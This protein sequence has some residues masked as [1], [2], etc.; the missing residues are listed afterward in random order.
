MGGASSYSYR[1]GEGGKPGV[2]TPIVFSGTV[3]LFITGLCTDRPVW[4]PVRLRAQRQERHA[5]LLTG[6][7][8]KRITLFEERLRLLLVMPFSSV[9]GQRRLND[10][11]GG[12]LEFLMQDLVTGH[13]G[14][15]PQR[16]RH[17]FKGPVAGVGGVG[18]S[19]VRG[20]IHE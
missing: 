16:V 20:L 11:P 17:H 1:T 12:Y 7:N 19:Q 14:G 2:Y 8:C 5:S 6:R 3:F 18:N 9:P 4:H 10:G 13:K 15:T